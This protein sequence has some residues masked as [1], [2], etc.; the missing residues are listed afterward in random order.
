MEPSVETCS[1]RPKQR[2][3]ATYREEDEITNT[4]Q[5]NFF[6]GDWK[7]VEYSNRWKMVLNECVQ[8]NSKR[9]NL[10]QCAGGS[11]RLRRQ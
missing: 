2:F 3:G 7:I 5:L 4:K 8:E 10:P 9:G 1:D 11:Y 6:A